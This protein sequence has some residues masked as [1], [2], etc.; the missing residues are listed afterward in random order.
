MGCIYDA[1]DVYT[2]ILRKQFVYTVEKLEKIFGGALTPQT[3]GGLTDPH[4]RWPPSSPLPLAMPAE[5]LS[6]N[7]RS[8][9][10]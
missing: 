9:S 3:K 10:Y 1:M 8:Q 5:L 4:P 7:M 2:V 6:T